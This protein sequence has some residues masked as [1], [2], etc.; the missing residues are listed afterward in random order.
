MKI[1]LISPS[2]EDDIISRTVKDIPCMDSGTFFAPHALEAVAAL[3][4]YGHETVLHDEH[5]R[6][7]ADDLIRTG[8]FDIIGGIG[9]TNVMRKLKDLADVIFIGEAEETWPRFIRDYQAGRHNRTYQQISKPDMEMTPMPRWDLI[10]SDIPRY[11]AVSVQ[12]SRG[13]PHDCSFCDVIYTYGRKIR[14]KSTGQ[15]IREIRALMD[16]GAKMIMIADDNF[17]ADRPYAKEIL[18]E[19]VGINN[20]LRMPLSFMTQVDFTVMR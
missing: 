5:M 15:V 20:A 14:S 10:G 17:T 18:R 9:T 11:G 16:L 4:P 12:T 3:T 19:L 6:G 2:S 13:C 8:G 1:L 7:P